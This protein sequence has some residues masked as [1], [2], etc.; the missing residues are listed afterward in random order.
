MLLIARTLSQESGMNLTTLTCQKV[1]VL[2][3][4]ELPLVVHHAF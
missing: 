3:V 1:T 4:Q 2:F